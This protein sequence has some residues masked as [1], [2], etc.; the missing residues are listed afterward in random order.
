MGLGL[1]SLCTVAHHAE[2]ENVNRHLYRNAES[3]GEVADEDL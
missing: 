2:S 1:L 3:E